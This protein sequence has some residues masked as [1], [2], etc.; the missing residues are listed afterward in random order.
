MH[1][2][3]PERAPG[4]PGSLYNDLAIPLIS[5]INAIAKGVPELKKSIEE[6]IDA[7]LL[8]CVGQ[9]Q[10]QESSLEMLRAYGAQWITFSLSRR[11]LEATLVRLYLLASL[12][13]PSQ[14]E[15]QADA[16][17]A[18]GKVCHTRWKA[19]VLETL[20]PALMQ[21]LAVLVTDIRNAALDTI[22]DDTASSSSSSSS[23]LDMKTVQATLHS[24]HEV[25]FKAKW[26]KPFMVDTREYYQRRCSDFLQAENVTSYLRFCD[27][28]L[29]L[30]EYIS[31]NLIHTAKAKQAHAL[32][33]N[34][35]VVEQQKERLREAVLGFVAD[36]DKAEQLQ[37]IHRLFAR[38]KDIP[39]LVDIF[40]SFARTK[41]TEIFAKLAPLLESE[42]QTQKQGVPLLFCK[43]FLE[44]YYHLLDVVKTA[45]FDDLKLRTSL[46]DVARKTL[47]DNAINPANDREE[48]TARFVA[49]FFNSLLTD[50]RTEAHS[51]VSDPYQL[52]GAVTLFELTASRDVVCKHYRN[53]LMH[54][55]LKNKT[56]GHD[57]EQDALKLLRATHHLQYSSELSI[58]IRD[59]ET[60]RAKYGVLSNFFPK[61]KL[62]LSEAMKLISERAQRVEDVVVDPLV[63]TMGTWPF[64]FNEML[65]SMKLPPQV[66]DLSQTF[67][68]KF[69]KTNNNRVVEWIHDL[70]TA[71]IEL[72][73]PNSVFTPSDTGSKTYNITVNHLQ[74]AVIMALQA[75]ASRMLKTEHFAAALE[76]PDDWLQC[77]LASLSACAVLQQNPNNKLWRINPR[78]RANN[79][80]LNAALKFARPTVES[81]ID[82]QIEEGR[83]LSTQAAIVR[84][85]KSRRVL[86]HSSLC[87]ETTRQTSRFFPQNVERIKRSIE[88]L[89]NGQEQYLERDGRAYRYV[90]TTSVQ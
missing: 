83:E 20:A 78:F 89:I 26:N 6:V 85:M 53:G 82:P 35:V 17:K 1:H 63:L 13:K 66:E 32:C 37:C 54:R 47:N 5:K 60:S 49:I 75:C 74:L 14:V 19:I 87:S 27:K 38:T 88:K 11:V 7:H 21:A 86:D 4:V 29:D 50:L 10:A 65:P 40:I 51:L 84:I 48:L 3:I 12:N 36:G 52:P 23:S 64:N 44:C 16:K 15:E 58:M 90:T 25:E 2:H 77:T 72:K 71:I 59:I 22:V 34:Q 81:T 43:Q 39:I 41:F 30:E 24:F 31:A 56:R 70:S 18:I 80:N 57:S 8:T 68:E 42:D 69:Q 28:L 76:V 55:L 33:L 62:P 45:F 67:Q 46:T 73:V 9:M 79:I 61:K